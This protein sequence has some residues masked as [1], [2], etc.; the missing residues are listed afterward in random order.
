MKDIS[1][2]RSMEVLAA[3]WPSAGCRRVGPW[4]IREGRGGGQRVSAATL[5]EPLKQAMIAEL[6][7]VAEAEMA[8]LE[9]APLFMVGP[10]GDDLDQVLDDAGY[11]VKDPSHLYMGSAERLADPPP[12]PVSAFAVWPP[13]AIMNELWEAGGIGPGRQAVMARVECA[14]TGILAR[15]DNCA[16]GVAFVAVH[17]GVAMLHALEVTPSQRRKGV[18]SGIMRAAAQWAVRQGAEALMLAV[19]QANAGAARLYASLGMEIVEQYH[20]RVHKEAADD[21]GNREEQTANGA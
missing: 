18:G 2:K 1:L 7:P 8:A 4:M 11:A 15:H 16:A 5:E 19:T 20:Y 21:A 13:L 9:Q 3:T 17:N 10:G 6:L 14:K 12:L